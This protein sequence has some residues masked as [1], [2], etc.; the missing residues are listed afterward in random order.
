MDS[1]VSW[2]RY[3]RIEPVA[4]AANG[5]KQGWLAGAIELVTEIADVDIDHVRLAFEVVLPDRGQDLLAREQATGVAGK[6]F[7]QRELSTREVDR[8][9]GPPD[10]MR[11]QIDCEIPKL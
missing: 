2:L 8:M 6:V 5:G 11:E 1:P 4:A 7:E 10:A 3:G 9:T